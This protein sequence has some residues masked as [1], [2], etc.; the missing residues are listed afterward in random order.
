MQEPTSTPNSSS[1]DCSTGCCSVYELP[2]VEELLGESFHP[3]GPELSE[4]SIESLHL[5]PGDQALDIA[6][7]RGGSTIAMAKQNVLVTAIDASSK[8]LKVAAAQAKELTGIHFVN[9]EAEA[10]PNELGPFQGILCEC[11]L[12]LAKAQGPTVTSWRKLLAPGGRIALSDMIVNGE[13]PESL[14]GDLG[15]FACIGGALSIDGYSQ[16]LSNAG[17]EKIEYHD[18]APALRMAIGALKKKLLLYGISRLTQIT[19]EIGHSISDIK[20]ALDDA[21]SAIDSGTLSYGRFSAR[22]PF[23]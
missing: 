20:R 14:Q 12:S 2:W 7:G 19:S 18:E 21:R 5:K 13:L 11:A 22:R 1:C 17:F 23:E 3:G 4:R 9:A 15:K 6:C 10:I 16:L 8:Q